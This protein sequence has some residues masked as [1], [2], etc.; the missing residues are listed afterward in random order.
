MICVIFQPVVY[1]CVLSGIDFFCTGVTS[2]TDK[3]HV[4][5]LVFGFSR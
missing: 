2:L 4:L 5:T 3:V 1:S